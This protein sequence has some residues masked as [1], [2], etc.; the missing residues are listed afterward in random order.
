MELVWWEELEGEGE[1]EEEEEGEEFTV[2]FEVV[3]NRIVEAK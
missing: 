3:D 2:G 1:G